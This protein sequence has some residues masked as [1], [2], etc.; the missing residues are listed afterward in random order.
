MDLQR[1]LLLSPPHRLPIDRQGFPLPLPSSIQPFQGKFIPP[2]DF[3]IALGVVPR[4]T[5]SRGAAPH[6]V[7]AARPEPWGRG[8]RTPPGIP[9]LPLLPP[10][11]RAGR[12]S[13]GAD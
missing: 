3:Q 7:A 1:S 2:R 9:P 12:R 11:T 6:G 13:R 5:R 4:L 10:P 8:R